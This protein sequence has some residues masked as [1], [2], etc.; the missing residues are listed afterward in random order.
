VTTHSARMLD[1]ASDFPA[2][3]QE[4]VIEAAKLSNAHGFIMALPKGYD[5]KVCPTNEGSES[6]HVPAPRA[7]T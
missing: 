6:H 5:T 4:E 3:V 7:M 2:A 1:L